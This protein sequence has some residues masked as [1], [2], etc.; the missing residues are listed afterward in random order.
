MQSRP[1]ASP[2]SPRM[3]TSCASV[4]PPSLAS[5]TARSFS[6]AVR[7]A[8]PCSGPTAAH[9]QGTRFCMSTQSWDSPSECPGPVGH[10]ATLASQL[11]RADSPSS[12]AEPP[13]TTG[14]RRLPAA[15]SYSF[16]VVGERC[17]DSRGATR[18][19]TPSSVGRQT[20]GNTTVI[21]RYGLQGTGTFRVRSN[22]LHFHIKCAATRYFVLHRTDGRRVT[23][24]R[25]AR[26][27]RCAAHPPS[28]SSPLRPGVPARQ[29][30]RADARTSSAPAQATRSR[31]P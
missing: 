3:E 25:R 21:R 31:P 7:A 22:L 11:S 13:A 30:R 23:A 28:R 4:S 19:G 27:R 18:I 15:C 17:W 10:L 14:D 29:T 16:G 24:A 2:S 5:S 12:G 20:V 26:W 1:T 6:D 8:S 9:P